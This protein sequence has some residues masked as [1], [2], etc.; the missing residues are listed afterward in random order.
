M[1]QP[2]HPHAGTALVN[3]AQLFYEIAGE[4]PAMALIHAGIA[5]SRMWDGQFELF[6]QSHR[7][8]RYDMRGFGRSTMPAG[9]YA[10]RDDLVDLLRLLGI[11]GA[12][13]VG[14]SMG[15]GVALDVAIE[16]PDVARALVLVSSGVGGKP[17][18]DWLQAKV[19]E[20]DAA[21]EAGDLDGAV[22]LEIKLWVDGP[23]RSP[24]AVAP[25][26]R[27]RVFAMDRDNFVAQEESEGQPRRLDPPAIERLGEV[28]AP[29]L[30][31]VGDEDVPD[32]LDTAD[33]LARGIPGARKEVFRGAGHMLTMERPADFTQLVLDFLAEHHH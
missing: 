23:R 13:L 20:I 28:R 11:G 27:E 30:V 32:V 15:G 25:A 12:A 19:D 21:Y 18:S 16:H 24:E 17:R 26:I 9:A 33:I 29:T 3:G 1:S 6:A 2:T 22:E 14:V 7:V 4:G 5:D 31:V 10:H 8:L